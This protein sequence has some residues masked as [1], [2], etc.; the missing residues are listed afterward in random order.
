MKFRPSLR[1]R[2]L[3]NHLIAKGEQSES[4]AQAQRAKEDADVRST[5]M[6]SEIGPRTPLRSRFGRTGLCLQQLHGQQG[7]L[8]CVKLTLRDGTVTETESGVV[9]RSGRLSP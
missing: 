8:A 2:L 7:L 3:R 4:D 9:G 5:D 6:R 1:G